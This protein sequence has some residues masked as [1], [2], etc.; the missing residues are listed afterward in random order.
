M[1]AE[2]YPGQKD[3]EEDKVMSDGILGIFGSI[4]SAQEN[5]RKRRDDLNEAFGIKMFGEERWKAYKTFRER[6][7]KPW[8]GYQGPGQQGQDN[9]PRGTL[10]SGSWDQG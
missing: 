9:Y 10:S 8:Q 5:L 4:L 3:K 1:L 7:K 6:R 2:V